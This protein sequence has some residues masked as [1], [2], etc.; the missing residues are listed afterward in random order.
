MVPR[1]AEGAAGKIFCLTIRKN[2][3]VALRRGRGLLSRRTDPSMRRT[4]S[5]ERRR[6]DEDGAIAVR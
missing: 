5:A 6:C 2:G 3:A 4:V 1:G